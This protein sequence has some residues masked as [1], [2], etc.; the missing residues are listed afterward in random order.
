MHDTQHTSIHSIREA[1]V[2]SALNM[3][4][5]SYDDESVGG[6][7]ANDKS[8]NTQQQLPRYLCTPCT[9]IQALHFLDVLCQLTS[10]NW[11]ISC[12]GAGEADAVSGSS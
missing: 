5:P 11:L 9:V 8:S 3:M 6:T 10:W 7:D 12:C 2:S 1:V 4:H